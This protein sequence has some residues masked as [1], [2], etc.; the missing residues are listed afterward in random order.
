MPTQQLQ[1]AD[2]DVEIVHKNIKNLH[3]SV[4]PPEG[5]V[6]VSAPDHMS[7]DAVR[8]F[9]TTKLAWIREEQRKFRAQERQERPELI[10]RE[11]HFVWGERY[12]LRV[13]EHDGPPAVELGATN[14][15][16][17]VRPGA[18]IEKRDEVLSHWYRGIVHDEVKAMLPKWE[19]RTGVN[20]E[21]FFVRRMKTKWGSCNPDRRTIRLNTELGKKPRACLEYILVHE[22]MHFH[23]PTH[24]NRFR[25]LMDLHLPTW[26]GIR[27]EL[28]RRALAHEEWGY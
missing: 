19:A 9:L 6:R 28:N 20:V 23:E 2:I 15:T 4:Y 26:R 5:H 17:R 7:L 8:A 14:L 24:N 12:L 21:R 11:S 22:L 13:V 16:L 18:G 27:N 1:L 25:D 10:D 3:L